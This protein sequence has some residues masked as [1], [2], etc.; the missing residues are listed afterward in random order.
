MSNSSDLKRWAKEHLRGIENCIFPSFD[1]A[2]EELD[3]EGIRLDVRQ[4][5]A[6]GF[7]SSL[8]TSEAGMTLA[9]AKRFLEIAVDEAGNDIRIAIT[10]LRDTH[11]QNIELAR[12]AQAVGAHGALLGFPFSFYPEQ[13]EEVYTATREIC[14]AASELPLMLYATHKFNFG[15][16]HPSGWPLDVLERTA[17]IPNVVGLK[18]GLLEPGFIEEAFARVG[19]RL[20]I[21]FPWERWWP[22]A[23]RNFGL[24]F[25]GAGAYELFQSPEKPY[26]VDCFNLLLD[27]R[28]DEAKEIYWRLTPARLVFEK[29]FMPTQMIGTYHWP[30]QKYYQWLTGGNGGYTRQPVMKML[31]PELDECRG[32]LRAIGIEPTSSPDAEF[33]LGRANVARGSSVTGA[34]A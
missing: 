8:L 17:A 6:H 29:Q 15:R 27:G 30:Q 2:L 16:F 10:L 18:I 9:E 20:V 33:F 19:D 1:P 12:H 14:D 21:Q 3:E 24:Q 5:I 4:S 28:Y 13:A 25:A 32:A 7:T 23:V 31:Q 34:I 11:E 22:L 26:L